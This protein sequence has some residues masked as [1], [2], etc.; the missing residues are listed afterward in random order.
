MPGRL[1]GEPACVTA[2]G[3]HAV[4]AHCHLWRYRAD[5]LPWID[6]AMA[7]LRRDFVAEDVAREFAAAGV[8]GGVAV[9]ARSSLAETEFLLAAQ[10]SCS[11]ILGVV[12]W[13]DLC[14]A[15]AGA[16]IERYAGRLAGV[17]HIA[18]SEPDDFLLR[19][20]FQRG[21]AR[22]AGAGMT[23]DILI[24]PRQLAAACAFADRNP[25]LRLVLDHLAKPPIAS[26][27]L[28]PWARDLRALARRPH[29]HVKASGLVTEAD[30]ARWTPD[31][32]RRYL[33]IAFEAFGADRVMFGSDFPVCT[34]AASYAQVVH[35]IDDYCAALSG[36]ERAGVMAD[37]A[38]AF[39]GL[40]A[41][42]R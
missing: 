21:V 16:V 22:L 24:Y 38:I 15:D 27:E 42:E 30:W 25:D 9:Q 36:G 40:G 11:A 32:L 12:G 18:Q 35:A 41:G 10:A 23:Y 37:N 8:R 33:D 20:D 2:A 31:Q 19:D 6:D 34:V 28:E 7:V 14:A 3:A 39:Y 1:E 29:V 17:R 26:G 13:V 5:E 4:D